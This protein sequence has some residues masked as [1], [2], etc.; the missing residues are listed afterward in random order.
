MASHLSIAIALDGKSGCC[1]WRDTRE[2]IVVQIGH[3]D[4]LLIKHGTTVVSVILECRGS[5]ID[6]YERHISDPDYLGSAWEKSCDFL[7]VQ[8]CLVLLGL[9]ICCCWSVF[10]QKGLAFS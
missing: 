4:C 8:V 2:L 10:C 9:N 6:D 5:G 3:L 7:C 1:C